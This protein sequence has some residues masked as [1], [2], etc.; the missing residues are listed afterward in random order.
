MLTTA[1][2]ITDVGKEEVTSYAMRMEDKYAKDLCHFWVSTF[3]NRSYVYYDSV[4]DV[5]KVVKGIMG[6]KEWEKYI[7]TLIEN[8]KGKKSWWRR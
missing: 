8:N 3:I 7:F 6:E 4:I 1:Q 5:L 2:F